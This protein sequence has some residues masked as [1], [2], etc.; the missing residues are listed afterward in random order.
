MKRGVPTYFVSVLTDIDG[1][2]HY[3]A[4]LTFYEHV[5]SPPGQAP[6]DDQ[7]DSDASP[8]TVYV[9]KSMLL[10]SRL[11]YFET[12]RVSPFSRKIRKIIREKNSENFGKLFEMQ[13]EK[14]GHSTFIRMRKEA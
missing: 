5:P 2:R 1:D 9:P 12:F 7:D 11:D 8:P 13:F 10:V 3:C 14:M 6:P 4:C